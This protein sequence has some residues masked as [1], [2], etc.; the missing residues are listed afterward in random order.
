MA[1]LAE[2]LGTDNR[3]AL[4]EVLLASFPGVDCF[5]VTGEDGPSLQVTSG[6]QFGSP[7]RFQ[8]VQYGGESPYVRWG[9]WPFF[10]ADC[11]KACKHGTP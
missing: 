9:G 5:S 11:G 3:L 2:G 7:L 1:T 8:R 10:L 4:P 6:R